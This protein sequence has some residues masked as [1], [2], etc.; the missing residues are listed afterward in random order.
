MITAS[1]FC[2]KCQRDVYLAKD[3]D[4]VCPVCSSALAP[5]ESQPPEIFLG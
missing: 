3:E 2:S 4:I 1:G 5:V